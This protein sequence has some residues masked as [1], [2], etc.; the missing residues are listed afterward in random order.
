MVLGLSKP[1]K[2][3]PMSA[4]VDP[5][6][7][8]MINN[9]PDKTGKSL[10]EWFSVLTLTGLE[11]HGD[12]MKFLKGE[13][14]VSHGFA[15]TITIL[16]RQQAAGGPLT[17]AALI[18]NQYA[19]AKADLKPIY[20]AIL[21]AVNRFGKDVEIA[22]KKSYVSLRRKKQFAIVPTFHQDPGRPGPQPQGCRAYR[23]LAGWHHF[24]WY[25]QSQGGHYVSDGN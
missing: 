11:K 9:M 20:E 8:T 10:D 15:N 23:T 21:T 1:Q 12:M 13:H 16:Y 3:K 7:Q 4:N 25:V 5:Q 19:G 6:T 17:E 18:A 14:G 22:P 2:E 24:Q